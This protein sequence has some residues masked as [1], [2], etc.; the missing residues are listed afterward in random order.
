MSKCLNP[1]CL[2]LNQAETELWE[3]CGSKLLLGGR[4][5]ALKIIGEGSF[6]RTFEGVD[7]LKPSKPLWAIKQF[8]PAAKDGKSG[9][10]AAELFQQEAV[11][12]ETLGKHPQIPELFAHLI[13][14]ENQYL[15]PEY[16]GGKNLG[17]ELATEGVFNENKIRELLY[18]LLPVLEFIHNQQVIH[19]D[20][21]PENI[22]RLPNSDKDETRKYSLVLVDFVA[23]K[24]TSKSAL[25]KTGTSIGSAAFIAPEKVR[26]KAVFASD[27][28]SLGLTCIYL[29]TGVEPF[30]LFNSNEAEMLNLVT[31]LNILARATPDSQS[32]ID[33][34]SASQTNELR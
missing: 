33:F 30:D 29:L 17:E 22:I 5:R 13:E 7:E 2:H 19:R 26:G 18:E 16:I 23:A 15:V 21:K 20:V 31:K 34:Q 6:G 1:N 14:D 28:F 4:Y 10:K 12:L 27:I 8:F 32:F 25:L 9:E 24:F 3:K 11:R